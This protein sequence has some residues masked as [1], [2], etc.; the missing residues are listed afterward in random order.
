MKYLAL[1]FT[2]QA[3]RQ[4]QRRV[5]TVILLCGLLL[6]FLVNEY[7]SNQQ[8]IAA[9]SRPQQ[10]AEPQLT[11]TMPSEQELQRD[12]LAHALADTLN[13]PWIEM[14][15]AIETVKQQHPDVYL[16]VMQ[17]D[18]RKGEIVVSGEVKRL[19]QLLAFI[20]SLNEQTLFYNVLPF[21][22]RQAATGGGMEFSLKIGWY[23]HE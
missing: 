1:N 8:R 19:E 15:A 16:K 9:I 21:S 10:T 3:R 5:L 14:L 12:R 13:T 6:V 18:A 11:I 17:P 4:R 7:L 23:S 20:R 22:Q 2:S